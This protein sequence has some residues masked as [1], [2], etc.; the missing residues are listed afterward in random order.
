MQ[1]IAS[2]EVVLAATAT[3]WAVAI[4]TAAS[5]VTV[6]PAGTVGWWVGAATYAAGA[7][8]CHQRSERSFTVAGQPLP[9]CARCTGIYT[10]AALLAVGFVMRS[11]SRRRAP[12]RKL[13]TRTAR[14]ATVI[15]VVP[16]VATLIYEWTMGDTPS[17]FVRA[18]AGLPLGAVASWIVLRSVSASPA[19]RNA[20]GSDPGVRPRSDS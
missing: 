14:I 7:V 9:V 16:T 15:A 5:L 18:A 4:F 3:T 10:G 17:N 1:R 13:S 2:F 19:F 20:T 8:V 12:D 6:R 11:T